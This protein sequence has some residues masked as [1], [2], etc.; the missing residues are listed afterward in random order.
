MIIQA[1]NEYWNKS[2]FSSKSL[3]MAFNV[4]LGFLGSYESVPHV[5]IALAGETHTFPEWNSISNLGPVD[6]FVWF[7]TKICAVPCCAHKT[8]TRG[9][10]V[11]WWSWYYI[12]PVNLRF[13]TLSKYFLR[14]HV[15]WFAVLSLRFIVGILK[16]NSTFEILHVW[17][18]YKLWQI[19]KYI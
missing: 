2:T 6:A 18:P 4:S 17:F 16:K 11:I 9:I 13:G 7:Y 8:R 12:Q 10:Y 14:K 1:T 5:V 19:C 3:I 15:M